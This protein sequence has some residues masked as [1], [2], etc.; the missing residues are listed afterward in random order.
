MIDPTAINAA[1]RRYCQAQR[2]LCEPGSAA[3]A[4]WLAQINALP[5]RT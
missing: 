4:H 2:A 1:W 5:P 3:Y